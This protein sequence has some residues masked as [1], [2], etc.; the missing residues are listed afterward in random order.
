M[1]RG[2]GREA[3]DHIL[4]LFWGRDTKKIEKQWFSVRC[5]DFHKP[6]EV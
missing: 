4:Y 3:I 6:T 5:H 1:E 2:E